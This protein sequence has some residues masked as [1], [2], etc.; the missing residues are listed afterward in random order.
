M[1][2]YYIKSEA[3]LND[4]SHVK[5]RWGEVEVK[6]GVQCKKVALYW[7]YLQRAGIGYKFHFHSDL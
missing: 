4:T 1:V 3:C 6:S 5:Q 7:E 2:W